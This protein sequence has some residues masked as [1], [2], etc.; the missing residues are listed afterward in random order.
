MGYNQTWRKKAACLGID[1]N[2]F[3]PLR[4]ENEKQKKAL[5]ICA[6]CSVL[7]ECR[8]H[9]LEMAQ[10][11][12]IHGIWGGLTRNKRAKL[13]RAQGLSVR[14]PGGQEPEREHGTVRGWLQHQHRQETSCL[15]C[16]DA[17]G[18]W[19]EHNRDRTKAEA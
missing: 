5:A 3:M 7:T 6:E 13:L 19:S 16:T 8:N 10:L 9:V 15:P 12:D 11:Q 18:R 1:P 2:I 4:G 17:Y 14:R